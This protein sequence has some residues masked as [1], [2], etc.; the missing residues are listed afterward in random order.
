MAFV[1]LE[2][3]SYN[4]DRYS[5]ANLSMKFEPGKLYGILAPADEPVNEVLKLISGIVQP[6]KGTVLFDGIDMNVGTLYGLKDI[7]KKISYIFERG[8]LLANLS[9]LENLLLPYDYHYSELSRTEKLN[10]IKQHFEYFQLAE[11]ILEERPAYQR[12]QTSKLVV[13]I[14][15]LLTEPEFLILDMPFTDL[16]LKS[17]KRLL[18]KITEMK[19]GRNTTQIYF[20]NSDILYDECDTCFVF[21][22]GR[23]VE[24]GTWD[25][26]I[27]SDNIQT[28]KIIKDYFEI[29]L[30]ETEI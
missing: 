3:V 20:S 21:E 7:R 14:R 15:A 30:D 25:E 6:D 2:N 8:S 18:R 13:I 22:N 27:L 29:E 11:A 17:K 12:Q 26:L 10:N 5:V 1:S 19:K 28:Q 23:I 24:I 16:E 4:S 9:I